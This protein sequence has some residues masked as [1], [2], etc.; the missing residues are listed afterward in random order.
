MRD[1]QTPKPTATDQELDVLS[2]LDDS[3]A[4]DPAG[5]VAKRGNAAFLANLLVFFVCVALLGL[6]AWLIVSARAH[7][8]AQLTLANEKLAGSIAQQVDGTLLDVEHILDDTVFQ[9]EQGDVTET[10]LERMQPVIV[11][12]IARVEQLKGL[13]IYDASGHWL[14]S[15]E[16][17]PAGTFNNADRDY[18]KFHRG[19]VTRE[20]HL[21]IPLISRSSGEWVIPLSRRLNDVYGNFAGVALATIRLS[22]FNKVISRFRLGEQGATALVLNDRLLIRVPFKESD[23]GRDLRNQPVMA[24]ALSE[25]S[26]TSEEKSVFDQVVRIISFDH[27]PNFPIAAVV[28]VGQEEVLRDWRNSSLVQTLVVLAFCA[29]V[30]IGGRFILKAVRNREDAEALLRIAHNSLAGANIKLAQLARDDGLTGI[31]NRRFFDV[32]LAKMFA[33]AQRNKRLLAVAIVDVDNFKN[34]NDQYGHVAGDDCL[35][36]VAAAIYSVV[37]RPEDLVAR[38]GGEEIALLLPDTDTEGARH[39]AES[40]RLAVQAM[41][42]PNEGSAHGVVTISVGVAARTPSLED[43]P[44]ALVV[45]ADRALYA[46]KEA[47]RNCVSG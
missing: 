9:I 34:F 12:K 30:I 11:N 6:N 42:I 3:G 43:L 7:E 26:G 35:R 29:F 4:S 8:V 24:R 36:R 1:V 16:A 44:E 19:N 17:T 13:F 10:M 23:I 22:Y 40:A 46:A 15:T 25:V 41:L 28:A 14:L 21:G 2:V 39:V 32:R 47:G 45:M 20:S 37:R 5:Q 27:S 31:A 18:F 33:H 38:Y